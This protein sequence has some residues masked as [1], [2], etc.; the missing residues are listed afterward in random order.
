MSDKCN[1]CGKCGESELK[2]DIPD[3]VYA[4]WN[5]DIWDSL[6]EI[7]RLLANAI[8]DE[9]LSAQGKLEIVNTGYFHLQ[10]V[11]ARLETIMMTMMGKEGT[12][13]TVKTIVAEARVAI[14]EEMGQH[15]KEIEDLSSDKPVDP[16]KLN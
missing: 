13:T 8:T 4:K 2:S 1:K 3:E 12:I 15:L 6:A 10:R 11:C 14:A 9:S 7:E 16:G 5:K